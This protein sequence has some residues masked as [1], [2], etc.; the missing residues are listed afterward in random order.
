MSMPERPPLDNV[1]ILQSRRPTTRRDEMLAAIDVGLWYCDLPFDVLEWDP[2]VKRHFWFPADEVV[3]IQKF[4]ERLHV[5][6]RE[7]TRQ[8]IERSI[9]SH[10]P[11]DIQYRTVAPPGSTAAGQERWVR[12]IGYTAY[13]DDGQPIR[14]DGVTV[15][16]TAQKRNEQALGESEARFRN[17]ADSAPVMIWVTDAGGR[18]VYLNRQW[19]EFTGQSE[20]E[21]LGF[22]WL[23]AVHED[24]RA[25]SEAV[26]IDAN[27]RRAPFRLDYRLRRADGVYRWA[28]DAAV[29]RLGSN[30]EYLGYVGSVIDIHERKESEGERAQLLEAERVARAEAERANRAKGDFLAVMSHE[31]RTPLNAIGGYAELLE[32]GVSAPLAATQLEYVARIQRSQRHLLGLI[33]SVLNFARIEGGHIEYDIRAVPVT[34]L[35][36]LVEPLIMPQLA[37][38]PLTYRFESAEAGLVVRADAEKVTQILLNLMSNAVKF[39]LPGG[40]VTIRAERTGVGGNDA[41]A[42]SVTDTGIGIPLDR[43]GAVFDPFVQVD[44][45]LTREQQGAGLGLAISRDLARGMGGELRV[46]SEM[47]VGSTFVVT[48]PAG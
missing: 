37:A 29:P 26:F 42:I 34:D 7:R 30:G 41:V 13:G 21:A 23:D 12:A 15:D 18:C 46:R 44:A 10:A 6:D 14:F 47:G 2:T 48:L 43:I 4:Y 20:A 39:T 28:A 3:T 24:D 45:R 31:L 16:I 19:Y 32:M 1:T 17:M 8:A 5:D 33:N 35:I 22:G 9:A 11:Y 36:A 40:S 27:E 38:R 25:L